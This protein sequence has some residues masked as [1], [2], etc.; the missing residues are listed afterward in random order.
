MQVPPL[1]SRLLPSRRPVPTLVLL[2]L[3]WGTQAH[4]LQW[5]EKEHVLHATTADDTVATSFHFVNDGPRPIQITSVKTGCDCVAPKLAKNT[6]APGEEGELSVEFHIG[7]RVGPQE[8]TIEVSSLGDIPS[9][10]SLRLSVRI[11]ELLEARPKLLF[12]KIGAERTP[13]VIRLHLPFPEQTKL[14]TAT[15][16]EA[17]FETSL[18]P[19]DAAKGDF[20]L[21]LTPLQ[22]AKSGQTQVTI[23]YE[24]AGRKLTARV[25]GAIR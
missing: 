25:F 10:D 20:E 9:T 16:D 17:G 7:A 5:K 12:W 22:T 8:R 13:G 2:A 3:L 24:H 18:R 23:N 4:A 15:A 6:Y 11:T 21:L 19:I 1:H 14:L